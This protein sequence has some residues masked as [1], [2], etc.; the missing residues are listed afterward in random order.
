MTDSINIGTQIAENSL[1]LIDKL[2]D[3]ID[4]YTKYTEG[5]HEK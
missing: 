1:Y 3:K 5:I 2:I 4:K